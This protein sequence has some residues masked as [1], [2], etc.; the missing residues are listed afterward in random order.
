MKKK[1][2]SASVSEKNID[3][4]KEKEMI[5]EV[6]ELISA[7]AHLVNSLGPNYQRVSW[8]MEDTLIYLDQANQKTKVSIPKKS[9]SRFEEELEKLLADTGS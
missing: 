7:A 8:L 2:K 5:K 1:S 9:A 3:E 6:K 4:S